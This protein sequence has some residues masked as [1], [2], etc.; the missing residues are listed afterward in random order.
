MS[1]VF[2]RA[3]HYDAADPLAPFA[4]RFVPVA[5]GLVYLDGN[6]LGRPPV[7]A[8]TS[9][10]EVLLDW[11]HDLVEAWDRWVDLPFVV[12]DR[13]G[14]LLGA[15]PGQVV[16]G[17]STSVQLYKVLH[18]LVSRC[19]SPTILV[20]AS[21]FPTDRYVAAGVAANLGGRVAF[22]EVEEPEALRAAVDEHRAD[23]VLLSMVDF[24]TG[25]RADVARCTS[26]AGVPVLWD[27]SHA[28]GVVPV[29]LDR[30]GVEAAVG[31]TYKYLH[32]GPGSPAF[33]YVRRERQRTW[34]Q[35]IWG[36]WGQRDQFVMGPEY[37][38][39]GAMHQYAVGTPP[40]VQL[41]LVDAGVSI[42][43]EAGITAIDAK[44]GALGD[45]AIECVDSMLSAATG[46]SVVTPRDAS[47][48][49][50]HV[51]I[52]HPDASRLCRAG[53]ARGVVAD[54]RPPDGLRLGLA[55]LTTSYTDV[56]RAITTYAEILRHGN[57]L[58][59]TPDPGRV[60]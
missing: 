14:A 53:R 11:G 32:G 44:R 54:Y 24:R 55:P 16:V 5:D 59:F 15:A 58:G 52:V 20:A 57:H 38:P 60:T 36:W 39:A 10:S 41:S 8:V 3:A 7:A 13:I 19:D 23:A 2:A 40:V 48:R 56:A 34:R 30:W 43:G 22:G 6:S 4:E 25:A 21:E 1:E 28:A 12:G 31:C 33:A 46:C 27:L 17:D 45:F 50:G 51:T 42:V 26:A 47:R 37:D 18:A 9:A 29:E 35:P 49:G